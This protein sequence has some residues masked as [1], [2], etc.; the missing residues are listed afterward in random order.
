MISKEK[1]IELRENLEN[2]SIWPD[3]VVDSVSDIIS[4]I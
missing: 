2:S 4:L 3:L 1:L